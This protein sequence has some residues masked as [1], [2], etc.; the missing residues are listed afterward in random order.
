M[1]NDAHVLT[2]KLAPIPNSMFVGSFSSAEYRVSACTPRARHA[3]LG[4][5]RFIFERDLVRAYSV[6]VSVLSIPVSRCGVSSVVRKLVLLV[7]FVV[8]LSCLCLTRT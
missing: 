4:H 2:Q 8:M 3:R 6:A 7:A 1:L 5:R